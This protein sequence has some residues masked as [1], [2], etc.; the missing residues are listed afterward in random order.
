MKKSDVNITGEFR[1]YRTTGDSG[2][3][4]CRNFC[5]I[6][7]SLAFNTYP[8]ADVVISLNA[9]LLDDPEIFKPQ[10]VHYSRRA[11]SWDH[12]DPRLPRTE[13]APAAKSF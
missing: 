4:V 10:V 8:S 5:P 13:T 7:G 11:L 3:I 9:A 1:S 6:C 2:S 12:I